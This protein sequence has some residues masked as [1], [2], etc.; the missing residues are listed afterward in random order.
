[1]KI[2]AFYLPQFHEINENNR[3]RG[4]GYTEWTNVKSAQPL[5]EGHYQPRIPLHN[6]YYNLLDNNVMS[7]QI[8]LAKHYGVYGF[9]FYHYW[10]NGKLLLEKPVENFLNDEKLNMPF[11]MCWANEGWVKKTDKGDIN[12]I[13]QHYGGRDDWEKHFQYLLP[14]FKD[15]RYIKI[16]GHPLFVIYRPD[17]IKNLNEML[18]CWQELM[19]KEGLETI[20][21]AYQHVSFDQYRKKDDSRFDFDIEYQPQ[22][23]FADLRNIKLKKVKEIR[24]AILKFI[25]KNFAIDLRGKLR[26]QQLQVTNYDEVWTRIINRRPA[27]KKNIPGAF[28]DWD[29]TVR[30]GKRGS[31]CVGA[32]PE[33]FKKYLT[34]QIK[35]CKDNYK[36]D[37]IFM[38]AW[39]EWGECGYLEP[40][41]KYGYQ[42]LE[43]LKNALEETGEFP[44]YEI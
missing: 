37:L 9:C 25:E 28:V 6:N 27:P 38:F 3:W 5:F 14:Y 13:E 21:F 41:E 36:K 22:Y 23:T 15:R 19:K 17:V 34:L 32:S 40:D 42:Y 35:N 11:C 24:R 1:M 16:E 8:K 26:P 12:I 44:N 20:S 30:Y 29:N 4:K 7:E 10:F 2:I 39:N 33:K 18:D 43:S 31:V